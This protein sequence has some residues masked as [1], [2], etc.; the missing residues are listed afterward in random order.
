MKFLTSWPFIYTLLRTNVCVHIMTH[1]SLLILLSLFSSLVCGHQK[2]SINTITHQNK[3]LIVEYKPT[4]AFSDKLLNSLNTNNENFLIGQANGEEKAD[5]SLSKVNNRWQGLLLVDGKIY[6]VIENIDGELI[7]EIPNDSQYIGNLYSDE[8]L[9]PKPKHLKTT[10]ENLVKTLTD[11]D[12][13]LRLDLVVDAPHNTLYGQNESTERIMSM[14]NNAAMVYQQQADI[15]LLVESLSTFTIENDPTSNE[16]EGDQ[17]LNELIELKSTQTISTTNEHNLLLLITGKTLSYNSGFIGGFANGDS[18]CQKNSSAVV[19]DNRRFSLAD[20]TLIF[21][22]EIGHV[23]GSR[24]DG[25][26]NSCAS[27]GFIMSGTPFINSPLIPDTFSQCSISAFDALIENQG[28]CLFDSGFSIQAGL[29]GAWVNLNT[30]GQGLMLDVIEQRQEIFIAWFTYERQA[31]EN[32]AEFGSSRHRWFTAQGKYSGSTADIDLIETTG[33]VFNA[34]NA[35][36]SAVIGRLKI[37]FEDCTSGEVEFSI[38]QQ[39]LSSS[40]PINRITPNVFCEE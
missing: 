5:V 4:D 22:H 37:T 32:N 1:Y 19:S 31:N 38:D 15:E 10:N 40:F 17:L 27:R 9:L 36:E 33:G 3:I 29:S 34:D 21:I 23:I 30:L 16:T 6:N 28:S 39:N 24:H 11:H 8:F 20:I 14:I 7:T 13:K 35:T 26:N 25:Q 2:V 18:L 12:R